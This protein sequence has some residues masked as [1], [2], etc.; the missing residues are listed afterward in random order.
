MQPSIHTGYQ[1]MDIEAAKLVPD[2]EAGEEGRAFSGSHKGVLANGWRAYF[3]KA[4]R[5]F[6]IGEP[7]DRP[8]LNFM[9]V[10]L[11]I[12]IAADKGGWSDGALFAFSLLAIV[13]FAE[14]LGF[15]TEQLAL[16]TNDTGG[17]GVV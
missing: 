2:A 4:L 11:A 16:H 13:P 14:R 17:E 10:F 12:S 8:W 7:G 3:A 5:M 6:F 15:V 1:T 9:M